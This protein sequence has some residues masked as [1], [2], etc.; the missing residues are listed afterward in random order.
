MV[1]KKKVEKKSEKKENNAEESN[2][3]KS[4]DISEFDIEDVEEIIDEKDEAVETELKEEEDK[5][6][7]DVSK[8]Y[9]SQV[10]WA[11]FLMAA[12]III[13]LLVPYLNNKLFNKF[14]YINLEFTK[15]KFGE[16]PFYST[17][18]P[19]TTVAP[20]TGAFISMD[21]VSGGFELNLRH[22]PRKLEY[23][24]VNISDNTVLFKGRYVYLTMNHDDKPCEQNIISAVTLTNFLIDFAKKQVRGAVTDKEYAEEMGVEYMECDDSNRD[25][26]IYIREGDET[27]IVKTSP[28]CYELVYNSCEV[29]PV[30]EK[31]ILTILEGYMSFFEGGEDLKRPILPDN[32][33]S[34][35]EVK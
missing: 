12:L 7:S 15:T 13:I 6:K 29:F 8:K 9:N 4:E 34:D 10:F 35:F 26:V 20:I 11:I 30:S 5:E 22:D 1:K 24:P 21:E 19:T 32:Q 16:V 27:K 18:V 2:I 23:I 3:R 33:K 28:T 17:N 25:T 14:N 31:F